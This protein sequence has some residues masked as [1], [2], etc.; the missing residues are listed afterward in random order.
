MQKFSSLSNAEAKQRFR[1]DPDT[2]NLIWRS[3]PKEQFRSLGSW[4]AWHTRW[5]GK[6]AG[7]RHTCTVGKT[8]IQV[9]VGGRLYYAHRIV[10]AMNYGDVP[11]TSQVD[12][13]DGDGANNRLENLRLVDATGQKRNV[14]RLRTNTSGHNGVYWDK[15]KGR[16][17]AKGHLNNRA[18]HLGYADSFD[19]AVELR[20]AFDRRNGFSEAHGKERAL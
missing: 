16:W 3:R 9:R 11:P 15:K 13:I 5:G 6:P 14:R 19:E 7:H 10:W 18:I 8:Y 4:K 20:S 12:H 1:Y 2:G 17:Y